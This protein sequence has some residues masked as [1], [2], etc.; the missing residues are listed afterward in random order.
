[1]GAIMGT[2]TL[3]NLLA[4]MLVGVVVGWLANRRVTSDGMGLALN[5]IIGMIGALIA[6]LALSLALPTQ[7]N[8]GAFNPL[9]LLAALGMSALLLA[10]ALWVTARHEPRPFP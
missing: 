2:T 5:A 10:L 9:S 3:W 8:I 7:F 6:G 1:M 4:W